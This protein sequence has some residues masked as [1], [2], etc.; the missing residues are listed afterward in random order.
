MLQNS[1]LLKIES[2]A[3]IVIS[4]EVIA[5]DDLV[6]DLLFLEPEVPYFALIMVDSKR[7]GEQLMADLLATKHPFFEEDPAVIIADFSNC[8]KTKRLE[9]IIAPL[10]RLENIAASTIAQT[11]IGP[12]DAITYN[13][14]H[15]IIIVDMQ[16]YQ[17]I[18][19]QAFD[20]ISFANFKT[21]FHDELALIEN[22]L[23]FSIEKTQKDIDYQEAKDDLKKYRKVKKIV[24]DI[25]LTK[26][27]KLAQLALILGFH[28]ETLILI[29][30]IK[31]IAQKKNSIWHEVYYL[32][33]MGYY[34]QIKG[35]IL[36]RDKTF[37]KA[38]EIC[39]INGGLEDLPELLS[40][41]GVRFI[42]NCD[43]SKAL[44][45]INDAF[46]LSTQL[47]LPYE[48]ARVLNTKSFLFSEKG[49]FNQASK[50]VNE[51]LQIALHN[52][53]H[54]QISTSYSYLSSIAN[55]KSNFKEALVYSR[56]SLT[57]LKQEQININIPV[58]LERI[59][60]VYLEKGDLKQALFYFLK[61]LE[62]SNTLGIEYYK[63]N[64]FINIGLIYFQK[65]E[66]EIALE[67]FRTSL[68][69]SKTL[70]L[71]LTEIESYINIAKVYL[72]KRD[73]EKGEF[74]LKEALRFDDE[75]LSPK[76]LISLKDLEGTFALKS[77]QYQRALELFNA[78]LTMAKATQ[79]P[80]YEAIALEN[81]SEVLQSEGKT[82]DAKNYSKKAHQIARD[83]KSIKLEQ[84][85]LTNL[86]KIALLEND[87]NEAK[88]YLNEALRIAN[89]IENG[90]KIKDLKNQIELI[91]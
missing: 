26:L 73:L 89:T 17:A 31:Q 32:K 35:N 61:A 57:I 39:T 80:N 74:Y 37:H 47:N 70:E 54:W 43:W 21:A 62:I 28:E 69:K 11:L 38:L 23:N 7:L 10:F 16:T 85:S 36:E 50:Y 9:T 33:F 64:L 77:K 19:E 59:A 65:G 41:I 8:L 15:I 68:K 88:K 58:G 20:L 18:F 90:M 1:P 5:Y 6:D 76:I 84:I 29:K 83:I 87:S 81:L 42:E 66:H 2:I 22:D 72:E 75:M 51:A 55:A 79:L 52:N 46:K 4:K 14:V 27:V 44:T 71:K 49:D 24:D 86:G 82:E 40:E 30:E 53:F 34:F 25:L 60:S 13:K 12:R 56:K 63:S 67:Y 48:Q 91:K 45:N 3:D 78:S